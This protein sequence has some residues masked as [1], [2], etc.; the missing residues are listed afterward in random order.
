[1]WKQ[2]SI[3]TTSWNEAIVNHSPWMPWLGGIYSTEDESGTPPSFLWM[4]SLDFCNL[5]KQSLRNCGKFVTHIPYTEFSDYV[6]KP[7]WGLWSVFCSSW[8]L[9]FF[10]HPCLS[11]F[12][13]FSCSTPSWKRLS[14]LLLHVLVV[15]PNT[16]G[17]ILA[18]WEPV[19]SWHLVLRKRCQFA[20]T[21]QSRIHLFFFKSPSCLVAKW[22]TLFNYANWQFY[23]SVYMK[24]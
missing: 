24:L 2:F 10:L 16:W 20:F 14:E 13:S 12:C 21:W 9:E 18:E 3:P 22:L 11:S 17:L 5:F 4:L 23:T 1:M 6:R 19:I 7:F 15:P 8:C